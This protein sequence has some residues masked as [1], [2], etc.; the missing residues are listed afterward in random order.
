VPTFADRGCHMVSV[1][2]PYGC[3]LGF[4]SF[5]KLLKC[6]LSKFVIFKHPQELQYVRVYHSEVITALLSMMLITATNFP[7][8]MDFYTVR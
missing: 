3:I 6:I 2:D 1:T 5:Q 7:P 8:N 4:L